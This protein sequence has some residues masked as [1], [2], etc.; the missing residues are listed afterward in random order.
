MGMVK[1]TLCKVRQRVKKDINIVDVAHRT[2][3]VMHPFEKG[4]GIIGQNRLD[5]LGHVTEFFKGD[6]QAV[7]GSRLCPVQLTI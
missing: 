1:G 7:N 4:I 3:V 6:A 2:L 5:H